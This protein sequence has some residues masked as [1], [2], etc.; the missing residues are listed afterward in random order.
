M[1]LARK[2]FC[3]QS[4]EGPLSKGLYLQVGCSGAEECG[5]SNLQALGFLALANISFT[6]GRILMSSSLKTIILPQ[7]EAP[8]VTSVE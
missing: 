5:P 2:H 7:V 6:Q 1:D 4:A 8:K 3:L